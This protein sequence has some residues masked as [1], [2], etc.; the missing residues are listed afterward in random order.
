MPARDTLVLILKSGWDNE[1]Y[2]LA[3]YGC[4]CAKYES[5]VGGDLSGRIADQCR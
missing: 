3:S 1:S 2:F 4:K 5:K